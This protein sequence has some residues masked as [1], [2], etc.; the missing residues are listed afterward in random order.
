MERKLKFVKAWL[1]CAI[2]GFMPAAAHAQSVSY[3]DAIR[4][5]AGN[6]TAGIKPA[7][8]VAIVRFQSATIQF[9]NRVIDDLN[10]ELLA[11]GVDVV[12]RQH[13]SAIHAEQN[14]Q[15][16]PNVD[17]SLAVGIGH[18]V[19]ATVII[20][21][22]GENLADYYRLNF[23][24]LDVRTARV[25]MPIRPV[26]VRYDSTMTR[27]LNNQRYNSG[28]IGNTHFLIGARLGMGFEINDGH[29][30][31]VGKGFSGKEKSNIAF[32][33]T[34]FGAFKFNESWLIQPEVNFMF[35]NGMEVNIDGDLMKIEYPTLD[36]PLLLRWNF[37]LEPVLAGIVL[38][39]YISLPIGKI[40]FSISSGGLEGDTAGYA[41]GIAGGFVVGVKVGPGYITGDLR[42]MNDFSSLEVEEELKPGK[43]HGILLRRSINLTVGYELSL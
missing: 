22:N 28:G 4:A 40:S 15:L 29:E 42:F 41:L 37:I 26:N 7:D 25:L 10:N 20:V 39:P 16:S 35:N 32:N 23:R 24:A 14:Y 34:L 27:L 11:R 17:D 21:G 3:N 36:I 19:A 38:G 43:G 30:N 1:F 12:T 6:I 18:E 13:L 2:L 33:A 5:I 8:V 9:T 31:M